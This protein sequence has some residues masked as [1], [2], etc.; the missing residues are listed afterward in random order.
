MKKSGLDTAYREEVYV[1]HWVRGEEYCFL[2][3]PRAARIP[4]LSLGGSVAS[5]GEIEADVLVVNSF[6]EL[7]TRKAEAVGKIVVFNPPFEN[8]GQCVQYRFWGAV[9]AAEA[10]AV[11]SMTR[12]VTPAY[13]RDVHTGSMTYADTIKK[14]PHI[15]IPP[16]DAAMLRRLQEYGITP[17]TKMLVAADSLED[18]LSYNLIVEL[19]G[20]VHPERIILLGGHSDCWDAGTGAHDDAGGCFAVWEA[21]NV[22]KKSG[23]KPKNTIRAVWFVNEENGVRGGKK[24]AEDFSDQEHILAMEFDSGVFAP[25]EWRF[26]DE[27]MMRKFEPFEKYFD[28]ICDTHYE[29]GAWG[30]DIGPIV[31]KNSIPKIGLNTDDR[32]KYFWYHHSHSDTPDKMDPKDLNDCSASIALLVY[33]FDT[34]YGTEFYE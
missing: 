32:G 6:E 30:V 19:K 3:H 25:N 21:L 16:E 20:T 12:S 15:A 28:K 4:M 9:R 22:L 34:I 11:A 24:Y 8:Y 26:G 29:K 5:G 10:G 31:E 14:I 18:A 27:E 33:I 23:Y 17:R 7:E 1:P 13:K 2:T